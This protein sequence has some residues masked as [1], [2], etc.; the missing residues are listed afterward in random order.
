[1]LTH[2]WTKGKKKKK[3]LSNPK[4]KNKHATEISKYGQIP[5]SEQSSELK[6]EPE[7]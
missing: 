6:P 5:M 1:M 3:S 4:P 2:L 7:H